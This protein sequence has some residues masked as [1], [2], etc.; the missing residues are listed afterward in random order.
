MKERLRRL[1]ESRFRIATQLYVGIGGAV[2]LTVGASLVGWFSFNSVGEAQSQVNE[3]STEVV[4]AFGVAQHSGTLVDAAP[5][6]MA[7]TNPGDLALVSKSVDE[8]REKL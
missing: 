3:S 4:A 1:F 2:V 6:V 8:A 5:R 7:A